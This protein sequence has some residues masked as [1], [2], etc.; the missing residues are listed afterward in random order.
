MK[1]EEILKSLA[2]EGIHEQIVRNEITGKWTLYHFHIRITGMPA[3]WHPIS[4]L[5][6]PDWRAGYIKDH[7]QFRS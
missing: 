2:A 1:Q 3:Y 7:H 6:I 5:E 4:R